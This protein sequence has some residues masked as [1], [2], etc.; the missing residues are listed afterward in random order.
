ME[1]QHDQVNTFTCHSGVRRKFARLCNSRHHLL[2]VA[3][4]QQKCDSPVSPADRLF[5]G[6]SGRQLKGNQM[7]PRR[8]HLE[9]HHR[10]GDA[11]QQ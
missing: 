9:L 1:A 3:M 11:M 8:L 5:L 2:G 7:R 4:V 10:I 6:C